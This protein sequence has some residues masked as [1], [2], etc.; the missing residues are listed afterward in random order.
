[1]LTGSLQH[2]LEPAS[3]EHESGTNMGEITKKTGLT[4]SYNIPAQDGETKLSLMMVA[5]S[6]DFPDVITTIGRR[7]GSEAGS[8]R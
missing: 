6:G 5:S 2:I 8:S 3:M 4:F 7:Y 1:M